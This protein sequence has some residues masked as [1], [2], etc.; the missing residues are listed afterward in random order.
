MG[1]KTPLLKN[2]REFR[3]EN[4]RENF[5]P[6]EYPRL[7][8][9]YTAIS[10]DYLLDLHPKGFGGDRKAPKQAPCA[11]AQILIYIIKQSVGSPRAVRFLPIHFILFQTMPTLKTQLPGI[12]Q[13][14]RRCN[15]LPE[16]ALK[17][18]SFFPLPA[19]PKT[20]WRPLKNL[21]HKA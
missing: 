21:F 6:R 19:A 9:R 8:D 11:L 18:N 2:I 12:F 10:F 5:F 14:T 20:P 7:L 16:E 17:R 13:N 15:I 3:K 4:L 1:R